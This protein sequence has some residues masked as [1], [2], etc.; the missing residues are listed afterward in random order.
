[1]A[2]QPSSVD[3]VYRDLRERAAGFAFKPDE[4]INEVRSQL[5][6]LANRRKITN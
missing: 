5:P 6:S 2:K 3:L 4:R 1:M